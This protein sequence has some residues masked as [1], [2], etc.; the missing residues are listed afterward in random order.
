MNFLRK[1]FGRKLNVK[2]QGNDKITAIELDPDK[3]YILVI[4]A[5]SLEPYD[6][7]KLANISH[8]KITTVTVF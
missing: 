7:E 1:L 8:S 4:K 3:Y 2:I 6:I 5:G